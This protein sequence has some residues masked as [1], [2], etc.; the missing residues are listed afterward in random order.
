[1]APPLKLAQKF[2]KA[3]ESLSGPATS[4]AASHYQAAEDAGRALQV[5]LESNLV[6]RAG[7]QFVLNR[8]INVMQPIIRRTTL[9]A[10]IATYLQRIPWA[11]VTPRMLAEPAGTPLGTA[12]IGCTLLALV[13]ATSCGHSDSSTAA[14][15][16]FRQVT[17]ASHP[18]TA[19]SAND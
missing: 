7:D 14:E 12:H 19:L 6:S 15:L 18:V 2:E 1:M 4:A 16:L 9:A 13:Q 17:N 8:Y 10:S 5:A 11:A 3:L